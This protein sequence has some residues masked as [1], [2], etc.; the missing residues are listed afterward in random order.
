MATT[1]VGWLGSA[2]LGSL[3][4]PATSTEVREP[5]A[6]PG[7]TRSGVGDGRDTTGESRSATGSAD[8]RFK[9]LGRRPDLCDPESEDLLALAARCREVVRGDAQQPPASEWSHEQSSDPHTR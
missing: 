1:R 8:R 2:P 4:P 6:N 7:L 9:D 5:G 3:A